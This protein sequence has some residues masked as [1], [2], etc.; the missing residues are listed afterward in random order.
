MFVEWIIRAWLA[1]IVCVHGWLDLVPREM[2]GGCISLWLF[3]LPMTEQVSRIGRS[4]SREFIGSHSSLMVHLAW[5]I[6]RHCGSNDLSLF[7][8]FSLIMFSD[9]LALCGYKIAART[10]RNHIL[11]DCN[12]AVE[13]SV[14]FSNPRKLNHDTYSEL[15][16]AN[17][18]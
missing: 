13:K 12:P 15:T 18:S 3:W 16:N 2:T 7:V 4:R 6:A 11:L 17:C 14:S 8:H 9:K 10:S 5:E 1:H